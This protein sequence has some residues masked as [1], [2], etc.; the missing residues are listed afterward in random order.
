M[1]GIL[2]PI[3][4]N[5]ILHDF[6]LQCKSSDIVLLKIGNLHQNAKRYEARSS[7]TSEREPRDENVRALLK[8]SKLVFLLRLCFLFPGL[9]CSGLS[10]E[11]CFVYWSNFINLYFLRF[12]I[13]IL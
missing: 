6:F 13:G 9:L 11:T 5:G 2:L 8:K 7:H 3:I 10:F 1:I 4:H 12:P